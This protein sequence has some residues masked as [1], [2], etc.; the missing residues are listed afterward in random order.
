MCFF[1]IIIFPNNPINVYSFVSQDR[2]LHRVDQRPPRNPLQRPPGV[3]RP[4]EQKV[5]QR[6]EPLMSDNDLRYCRL[7]CVCSD[8]AYSL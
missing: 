4:Q 6:D 5:S 2:N 1:E 7:F 8:S 3:R